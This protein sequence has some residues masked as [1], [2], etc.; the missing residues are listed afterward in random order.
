M[1]CL[2]SEPS[3]Q[4]ISLFTDSS[5]WKR[6][7]GKINYPEDDMPGYLTPDELERALFKKF[8][9]ARFQKL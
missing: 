1:D 2:L 8:I 7:G 6:L 5:P 3:L 4:L 9:S